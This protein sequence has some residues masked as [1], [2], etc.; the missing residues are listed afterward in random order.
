MMKN[1][2]SAFITDAGIRKKINEMVGGQ[3]GDRFITAI[4]SAVS[5]NPELAKCRHSTILSCA[6]LGESLKL[7]PSP[8]L[9]QYYLV[10]FKDNNE[11]ITNAVFVLGYRGYIQLAIRSGFYRKIHACE[12]KDG[13]LVRA[14][15]IN[16]EYEFS[17]ILDGAKRR[18]TPTI[19]YY[20]M[21]EYLNGFKKSLYWSREEM[22]KHAAEYSKGYANDL[23][24]GTKYTFWSKSFDAMALKTMIRQLISH[25]GVMS[26][27]MQQA[28]EGDM[29][30]ST[31][32]GRDYVEVDPGALS[33]ETQAHIPEPP[34]EQ[35]PPPVAPIPGPP[36]TPPPVPAEEEPDFM[37]G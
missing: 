20:A 35:T 4:I 27:E 3:N 11:G 12:I 14:D 16:D 2:F 1:N 37:K 7:S 8:Q 5:T 23:R 25:W 6:L 21:F 28:I 19:G 18:D 30:F 36:P 22:Q 26:A 17:P 24:K 9:G 10:P 34:S 33:L 13:E 29:S 15:P 32:E 31:D